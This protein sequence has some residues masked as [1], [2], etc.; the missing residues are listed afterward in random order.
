MLYH[1]PNIVS[2]VGVVEF[3]RLVYKLLENNWK[4][5]KGYARIILNRYSRRG[6]K[7]VE[8]PN[9]QVSTVTSAT[10]FQN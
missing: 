5:E 1:S 10:K 2:V 3:K 4:T 9:I 8:Y 7:N 6:Y